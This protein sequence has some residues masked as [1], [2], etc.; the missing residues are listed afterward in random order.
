MNC[1]F[2]QNEGSNSFTFQRRFVSLSEYDKDLLKRCLEKAPR[3]WESFADRFSGLIYG[4]VKWSA[5]K[6]GIRISEADISDYVADVFLEIIR[7]DFAV[8][9]RFRANASLHTYL[10]VIARRIVVRQLASSHLVSSD[11]DESDFADQSNVRE[12][13]T[14]TREEIQL[15]LSRLDETPRKL[16]ELFYLEEKSYEEIS[17][18]LGLPINSIGPTLARARAKMRNGKAQAS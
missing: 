17:Q 15:L 4:V 10:T 9:R 5:E 12:K 6:R 18:T 7:D 3:A 11:L 13:F 2:R 8:L 16:V 1:T 14:E